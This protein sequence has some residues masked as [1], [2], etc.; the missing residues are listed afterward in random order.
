MAWCDECNRHFV[1]EYAL[2]QHL[3]YAPVHRPVY[4]CGTCGVDFSNARG[5]EQHTE[6]SI[7]HLKRVWNYVCEP[8]KWGCSREESMEKHDEAVHHWCKLHNRYFRNENDLRQVSQKLVS[9]PP[10]VLTPSPASA[11]ERTWAAQ[12]MSWVWP[13]L[14]DHHCNHTSPRVWNVRKWDEPPEGRPASLRP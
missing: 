9:K 3:D 10:I 13:H 2:Q 6:T 12:K 14:S 8:C 5:L 7:K 11:I 4:H 1:N